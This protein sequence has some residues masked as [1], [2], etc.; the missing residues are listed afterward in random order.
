MLAPRP[1]VSSGS[2]TH[3]TCLWLTQHSQST[4]LI[5]LN[6]TH[7]CQFRRKIK[8]KVEITQIATEIVTSRHDFSVKPQSARG[9]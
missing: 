5:K 2:L 8:N 9:E 6:L 4:K 1:A 3:I 7:F